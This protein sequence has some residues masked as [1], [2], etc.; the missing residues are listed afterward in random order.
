LRRSSAFTK[1]RRSGLV[2]REMCQR[3]WDQEMLRGRGF[4]ARRPHSE[5]SGVA[6]GVTRD[7][8]IGHIPRDSGA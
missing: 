7:D 5:C 1:R 8:S 3:R 6:I 2:E 4:I